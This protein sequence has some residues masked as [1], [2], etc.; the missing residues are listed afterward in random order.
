MP[1]SESNLP[2]Q[3]REPPFKKIKGEDRKKGG[4]RKR[5]K[6]ISLEEKSET[7][8]KYLKEDY[9][10]AITRDREIAKEFFSKMNSS[11]IK[12][13]FEKK[14]F[15]YFYKAISEWNSFRGLIKK[16]MPET[17]EIAELE[18]KYGYQK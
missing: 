5:E 15:E 11:Q 17:Q 2:K 14:E 12:E 8:E 9:S 7:I 10:V 4:D 18:K 13:L 3:E 16:E 6:E 1:F